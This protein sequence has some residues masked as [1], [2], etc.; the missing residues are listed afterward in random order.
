[1]QDGFLTAIEVVAGESSSSAAAGSTSATRRIAGLA[2]LRHPKSATQPMLFPSGNTGALKALGPLLAVSGLGM[3]Y[4]HEPMAG[5][6][7]IAVG[8]WL[9]LR[10]SKPS[11]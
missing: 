5:V 2:L 6:A 3:F 9:I 4:I 10:A 7:L 8:A 11:D 1:M